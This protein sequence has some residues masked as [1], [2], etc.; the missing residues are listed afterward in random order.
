M[1]WL[2]TLIISPEEFFGGLYAVFDVDDVVHEAVHHQ[3][4][5]VAF[6][7]HSSQ[8]PLQCHLVGFYCPLDL[9]QQVLPLLSHPILSILHQYNDDVELI[10]MRV[11]M[12]FNRMR[13][14]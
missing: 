1:D 9:L 2:S 6:D 4:G 10:L 12:S 13:V 14:K 11:V 7:H 3:G 5:A 8:V